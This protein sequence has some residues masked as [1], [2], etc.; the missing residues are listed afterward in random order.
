M[1]YMLKEND[2]IQEWIDLQENLEMQGADFKYV[3]VEAAFEN[4]GAWIYG[5][6]LVK[7]SPGA[8]GS[9]KQ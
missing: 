3:L 7:K 6:E 5:V 1:L 4:A 9:E 8:G 2:P